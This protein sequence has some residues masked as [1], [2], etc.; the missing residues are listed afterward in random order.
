MEATRTRDEHVKWDALGA[1]VAS[2]EVQVD[3]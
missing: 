1:S 2:W 3:S